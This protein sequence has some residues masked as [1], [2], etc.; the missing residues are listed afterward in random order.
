MHKYNL[1]FISL[2]ILPFLFSLTLSFLDNKNIKKVKSINQTDIKVSSTKINNIYSEKIIQKNIDELQ[3]NKNIIVIN[4][5]KKFK[6]TNKIRLLKNS[7]KPNSLDYEDVKSINLVSTK[8]N[9]TNWKKKFSK[10]K[11]V[12]IQTLL[13]LIAYENQ[14]IIL[15]RKKIIEIKDLL[16]SKNTLSNSDIKYLNS[17]AKKYKIDKNNKHK[18]DLINEMLVNVDII[19]NSIV[20]AQAINESGWGTSRFAREYN[21][22]FGQ[23]TY[24]ENNGIVPNR[25]DEGKKHLIKNFKSINKSVESYFFNINTHYAYTNFRSVRS[26]IKIKSLNK[27]IK[28]LTEELDVYAEDKLYV[29]TINSIIDTNNLQQF[30]LKFYTFISS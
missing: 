9:E 3:K 5:I 26:A 16:I 21:A 2:L 12:F 17:I 23:Y 28:Q 29:R 10:K 15:E 13:P 4:K 11:I 25:R 27:N 18:I 7:L 20:L 8:L 14:K 6:P 19:P 1:N 24:D 22:L 30:D